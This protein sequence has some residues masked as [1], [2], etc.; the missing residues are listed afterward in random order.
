MAC[1]MACERRLDQA[2]Y[3]GLG[4]HCCKLRGGGGGRAAEDGQVDQGARAQRPLSSFTDSFSPLIICASSLTS[5]SAAQKEGLN[6]CTWRG[7]VSRD[8][9]PEGEIEG[10]ILGNLGSLRTMGGSFVAC[11]ASFASN[12]A[13]E[14]HQP[15]PGWFFSLKL[16]PVTDSRLSL[17]LW[18]GSQASGRTFSHDER[19]DKARGFIAKTA[20]MLIVECS[21]VPHAQVSLTSKPWVHSY[22]WSF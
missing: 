10:S 2:A 19:V 8:N 17:M 1:G 21:C 18:R 14:N 13:G 15:Q 7:A 16:P 4:L 22:P 6:G 9:S 20:S 3:G 12:S 5:P 11:G